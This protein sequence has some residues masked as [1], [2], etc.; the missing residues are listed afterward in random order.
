[1]T[2]TTQYK[3][4]SIGPIPTEWE[5]KKFIEFSKFYSG[6]TPLTSKPQY[7]GGEI[8]FIKSGEIYY[9][10]TEQFLS[11]EGLN[12]SSA[13]MVSKGDL[14]Y[15]LY[16]ANS[17]EVAISQIDGAINQA[18]LCINQN[19]N[20][21]ETIYLYNYLVLQKDIIIKKYLQGGQGN[22]S[23]DII[24]KLQIPLPP[25]PEQQKIAEVLSTWDKAIQETDAII[26]KLQDRNKALAFSLLTGKKRVKGFEDK[27]FI[28]SLANE[29]FK[30]VSIKN[31]PEDSVLLS[32]TQEFGM[33]PRDM[34]ETRVTMPS[35]SLKTYKLVEKGDF[36]ISL[37]S[38]Q[39]GIE[40]SEY[41]GLVS[42]AYTVLKSI[43]PIND[44]FYKYYFKSEDLIGRLSVAVIGI[45]D[46][47]NISYDDFSTIVLP[48]P[49]LEEQ[50]AIAAIL[51][52]ANQELK[53]YQEK[54]TQIK[55]QKKGLMQQLLTGKV[56]TV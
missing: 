35:G 27:E 45:R 4:T 9:N 42:P 36:V 2:K 22:L 53:Q 24:K 25:L 49:S 19:K 18:I 50:N 1:M 15:A 12:N 26:K 6:G 37:R 52:I 10:K 5:V 44:D 43:N 28:K 16:G 14:L 41:T 21:A 32:A 39:G 33:I 46:G 47:K 40:Y 34:I 17:G 23:A 48:N 31:N 13:K 30:S 11:E 7:Y 38:F 55:L 29:V 20:Q 56:R 51:N 54:L 8:P 3:N